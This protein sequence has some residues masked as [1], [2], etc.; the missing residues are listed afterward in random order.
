[1]STTNLW[2]RYI[3]PLLLALFFGLMVTLQSMFREPIGLTWYGFTWMIATTYL[4]WGLNLK[5][6]SK[7]DERLP[8]NDH[9]IRRLGMQ[10]LW[11][12]LGC[13]L[14]FV[15]SYGVLNWYEN[16]FE[17]VDNAMS[18]VHLASSV[19]IGFMLTTFI[20]VIQIGYQLIEVR[21]SERLQAER[22][23]RDVVQARLEGLKQQIDPHFLFNNFSTLYGLIHENTQKAGA[24]L[25]KL[26]D[27]YRLVLEHLDRESVS[28]AEELALV[29]VYT[30]L[31]TIRYGNALRYQEHIPA[32]IMDRR[33]IPFALQ[34]L[35]ENAI[36]H[37]QVEADQPLVIRIYYT[38]EQGLCVENNLIPRSSVPVSAKIGLE[39]LEKRH[40]Y[41]LG[42]S[43]S[44]VRNRHLFS[45]V[46]PLFKGSEL[47]N[48][49][50][51]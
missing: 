15:A 38:P 34:M 45:V 24:F 25:L 7:L 18:P 41:R 26:S 49:P 35:V 33:M 36:K 12:N 11:S 30:E 37:N 1:M 8:W 39:N 17:G 46:I 14:V 44:I 31:V 51:Q 28:V 48:V 2:I 4:M 6:G 40:K 23:Q 21:E 10:C 3:V 47:P 16:T 5:I 9:F 50:K 32:E 20:N 42:K 22:Y 13:I 19:A 43:I 29:R 27:I